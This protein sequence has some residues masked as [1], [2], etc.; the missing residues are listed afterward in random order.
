[1]H[2][3]HFPL[4]IQ[5]QMVF[6]EAYEPLWLGCLLLLYIEDLF[7]FLGITEFC[8]TSRV[9]GRVEESINEFKFHYTVCILLE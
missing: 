1:M 4:I 2:T 7:F 5:L 3:I 9:V 8:R 6:S